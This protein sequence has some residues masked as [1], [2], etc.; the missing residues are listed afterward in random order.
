MIDLTNVS[1][2]EFDKVID[3]IEDVDGLVIY[4][5]WKKI[6]A[7]G[8]PPIVIHNCKAAKLV[9]YKIFGNSKVISRLP[10]EYQE[11][12]YLEG[13]GDQYFEIDHLPNQDTSS[14]GKYQITD[15]T[16]GRVLFGTRVSGSQQFY[17]FNWGGGMPYK[18]YNSYYTGALCPNQYTI[19]DQIH[20]FYKKKKELYVDDVL[21]HTHTYQQDW[22]AKYKTVV[23]ACNN[24]GVIGLWAVA[25]IFWLQF[26][27]EDTLAVD[28]VPCYRK[29]D[30]KP[31]MYDLVNDV[32]Y[33]N[34]GSGE[35]LMG[36]VIPT[37]IED[38]GNYDISTDTYTIP[39][40][41]NSDIV[42]IS[43]PDAL[44]KAGDVSDYIDYKNQETVW[45]IGVAV[46]DGSEDWIRHTSIDGGSVFRLDGV[47]N[48]STNATILDTYMSHFSVTTIYSTGT[49]PV[50][51]YR[52]SY[53]QE[54]LQIASGGRLY[55]ST[56]HETVEEFKQWL[57]DN[58]PVLYYPLKTPNKS[59]V[60]LPDISVGQYTNTIDVQTNIIPSN[61]EITY[62]GKNK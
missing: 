54:T 4:E 19:N 55:V 28:L 56:T 33:T 3:K 51:V 45:N 42:N 10:A 60:E 53:N 7:S 58:L 12:E 18:Y 37:N 1:K 15:V 21:I 14:K 44:R 32:F 29:S 30:N 49:W 43:I 16:L 11:V 13:L 22:E 47:L 23:F 40:K 39:V 52:F 34:Q 62:L 36:N 31:G 41:T 50:G 27:D 8:V 5:A 46:F 6:L 2:L 24:N 26:Y 25:R 59:A 35:F 61:V 38:L 20:T 48:P 9:D 57:E 17:G